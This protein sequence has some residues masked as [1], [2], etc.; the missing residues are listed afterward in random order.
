MNT[1]RCNSAKLLTSQLRFCQHH[2]EMSPHR[3]QISPGVVCCLSCFSVL[4]V[5]SFK[6]KYTYPYLL[7]KTLYSYMAFYR[8]QKIQYLLQ[9]SEQMYFQGKLNSPVLSVILQK[10]QFII[11][12]C[13]FHNIYQAQGC[14]ENLSTF[15]KD[16]SRILQTYREETSQNTK[17]VTISG[18]PPTFVLMKM[19]HGIA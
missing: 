3:A 18:L 4:G 5:L 8:C 17:E 2:K 10:L 11:G 7:T 9:K 19:F 12:I 1:T 15:F 6:T 14:T 16:M 13:S